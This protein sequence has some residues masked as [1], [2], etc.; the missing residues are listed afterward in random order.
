MH[1]TPKICFQRRSLIKQHLLKWIFVQIKWNIDETDS[2]QP[3]IHRKIHTSLW[4]LKISRKNSANQKSRDFC[5]MLVISKKNTTPKIYRKSS[6]WIFILCDF[7][8]CW[9]C[10]ILSFLRY[11][12]SNLFYL[13]AVG[14]EQSGPKGKD[15]IMLDSLMRLLWWKFLILWKKRLL[16]CISEM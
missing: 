2:K 12:L 15:D 1:S 3:K 11:G 4:I 9:H 6:L 10:H 5:Q 14:W 13:V 7:H 16:T 8:L